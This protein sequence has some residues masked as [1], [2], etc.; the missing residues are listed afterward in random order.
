MLYLTQAAIVF[1]LSKTNE[2]R[3]LPTRSLARAV[4]GKR[5]DM[6]ASQFI[7]TREAAGAPSETDGLNGLREERN[8]LSI[9]P[10]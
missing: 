8:L 7:S 9:V 5:T 6:L 3:R 4:F 10:N 2:T 1:V